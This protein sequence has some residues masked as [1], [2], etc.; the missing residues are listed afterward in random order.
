MQKGYNAPPQKKIK[1]KINAAGTVQPHKKNLQGARQSWRGP[2]H[3]PGCTPFC[4][5]AAGCDCHLGGI[6]FFL[7]GG[8]AASSS[9][10]G[11]PQAAGK[12]RFVQLRTRS[13][14][15]ASSEPRAGGVSRRRRNLLLAPLLQE[16]SGE[17]RGRGACDGEVGGGG[18]YYLILFSCLHPGISAMCRLLPRRLGQP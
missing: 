16:N 14:I 7:G 12:G 4:I 18:C 1:I 8:V 17:R 2:Q 10:A 6:Y 13:C 9:F 5:A 3:P 15:A 11:P